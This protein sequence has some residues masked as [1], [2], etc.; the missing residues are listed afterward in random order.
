MRVRALIGLLVVGL[1]AAA[2][3]RPVL[4]TDG[5]FSLGFGTQSKGL[6]GAGVALPLGPL[7]PATNPAA[8]VLSGPGLDVGVG[9]F[10]PNRQYN[11]IGNPSMYPGTFGLAPGVVKSDKPYFPIPHVGFTMK[12]GANSVFNV[13]MY[14]NGGMNTTYNAPTF[15]V[16]PAG[17]NLSQMFV[18][19][20]FATAFGG[21]K[22]AIGVSAL[23]AY[24]WFDAKG[25]AAFSPFSSDPSNLTD[26]GT[27]R[28]L[29]A[30]VRVGY[31]GTWSPGLSVG[32]SYQSRISMGAF[33]KYKG[34]YA[35]QGDFDI[36]SNWTVGIALKPSSLVD[37]AFDVQRINYSEVKA[38]ANPMLPNL[39]QAA[40][41]AA[42]GAG[43]GWQ[44]MTIYKVG[45]QHRPGGGW[46]WRAG[47]AY[48]K[49]PIPDSEVMFNILAPGVIEQHVTFGFSREVG[50]GKSLDFALTRALSKSVTGPNPL[51]VPGRQSIEL[52]MDQWEYTIGYSVRF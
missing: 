51:D 46:T 26:N 21:G 24:Q 19:P 37:I 50:A 3:S 17:V 41:G 4:A 33:D 5:Y 34:L 49:Q 7:S 6:A 16:S 15:G 9:L 23:L 22:H 40:L 30:G 11:V 42:E 1:V 2:T 39:M 12:L 35:E 48:G 10:N 28:S 18:A 29:G 27:S 25:L 45:L 20:T 32:A 13:A 36:P 8:T 47:Y 14:G 31:L 52:K 43:F 38:I 44:D